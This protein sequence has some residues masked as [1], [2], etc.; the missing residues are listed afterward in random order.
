M[1]TMILSI[2]LSLNFFIVQCE[3]KM[4]QPQDW[5]NRGIIRV[6][7]SPCKSKKC[8]FKKH[9]AVP[10]A[11]V[12]ANPKDTVYNCCVQSIY[13]MVQ[14]TKIEVSTDGTLVGRI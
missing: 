9:F 2:L 11:A 8:L 5:S 13:F 6:D 3:D 4:T 7:T 1:N 10:D 12:K 14:K